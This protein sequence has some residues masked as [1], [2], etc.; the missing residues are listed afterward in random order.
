MLSTVVLFSS[1]TFTNSEQQYGGGAVPG[2]ELT[3]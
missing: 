1:I 2:T 3:R